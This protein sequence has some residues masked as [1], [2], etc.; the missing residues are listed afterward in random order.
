M[1]PEIHKET[2]DHRVDIWSAGVVLFLLLTGELPF[3]GDDDE[4]IL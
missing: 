3:Y 2:Y 4:Q 1:A